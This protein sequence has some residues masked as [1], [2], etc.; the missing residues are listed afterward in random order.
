MSPLSTYFNL[1]APLCPLF[2]LPF[3]Q[4][5]VECFCFFLPSFP[6]SSP[7]SPCPSPLPAFCCNHL[8]ALLHPLSSIAFLFSPGFSP[9]SSMHLPLPALSFRTALQRIMTSRHITSS[10]Y[11]I[12]QSH[13][14]QFL[15][16]PLLLSPLRAVVARTT[17]T[18]G[19]RGTSKHGCRASFPLFSSPRIRVDLNVLLPGTQRTRGW[20]ETSNA[21]RRKARLWK[22]PHQFLQKNLIETNHHSPMQ[23]RKQ[24]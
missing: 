20:F 16:F 6:C 9:R 8:Y 15:F 2:F 10:H 12:G 3:S 24:S 21:T 13:G 5:L 23:W 7:C 22:T 14:T 4:L 18:T 19:S 1:L 17:R 11:D